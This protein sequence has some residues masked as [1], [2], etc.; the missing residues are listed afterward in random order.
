VS[1]AKIWYKNY[2]TDLKLLIKYARNRNKSMEDYFLFQK[3]Q[4][5][6][7]VRFLNN[8]NI[9]FSGKDFIGFGVWVWRL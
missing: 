7:L 1:I 6:L 3:Y 4:G 5:E 2:F 8:M 9:E